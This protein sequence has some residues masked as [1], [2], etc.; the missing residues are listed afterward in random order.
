MVSFQLGYAHFEMLKQKIIGWDLFEFP[1]I[2][3]CSEAELWVGPVFMEIW[4]VLGLYLARKGS[5]SKK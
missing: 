4:A 2:H 1:E 3:W 5:I